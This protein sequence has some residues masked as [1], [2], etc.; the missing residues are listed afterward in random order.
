MSAD[1]MRSITI[2][3]EARTVQSQSLWALYLRL[4]I[5]NRGGVIGATVL[6]VLILAAI[7]APWVATHDPFFIDRI[8]RLQGP[9]RAHWLGTDEFGR[10]LFSRIV[11]G[12][13]TS[14]T[15]AGLAIVLATV[16]GAP[17][18][19]VAG[20]FGGLLDAVIMRVMDVIF[21]FPAILLALGITAILGPSLR[22][23]AIALGIVYAPGFSRIIRGPVLAAKHLEYVDASRVMGA[24]TGRILARHMLPNVVSPLIVTATV[25]FS[26]A[27]LAEAALSFLGLGAQPPTP[28]WGGMLADG[29][30]FMESA[31]YLA[32]FPGLAVMMGVLAS[33]LLGDALRDVLDPRLRR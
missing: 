7:F 19:I 13:R 24:S 26:F 4:F 29:R 23:A 32:I 28:S 2:E 20:Y 14:M 11:F 15:V 5:R 30:R 8:E 3:D 1:V 10:D 12:A 6:G 33:N 25:T 16:I 27:L 21:S 18:G 9:S 22:N 17:A 31:P